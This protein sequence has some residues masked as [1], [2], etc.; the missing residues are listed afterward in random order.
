MSKKSGERSP[1]KLFAKVLVIAVII[2]LVLCGLGFN[3]LRHMNTNEGEA[4][5]EAETT[6]QNPITF[7]ADLM[8][9]EKDFN[10]AFLGVDKDGTRTDV[11]FVAHMDAK[12]DKISLISVPRDTKVDVCKEVKSI[13][14]NSGYYVPD[15]CKINEVHAYAKENGVKCAIIQLEDLL[16]IDID[17]YGKIDLNG[18]VELVDEVGGIDIDVPSNMY[19][20]DPYQDLYINLQAGP[21]H[22]D[23]EH[24]EML[25][26]F[27]SYPQG[28]VQRVAV[29]QDF[30]KEVARKLLDPATVKSNITGYI[31]I[32][33]KY[34]DTNF[35]LSALM[36]YGNN[37]S[38][39]NPDDIVM[40][41]LPGEGGYIGETSYYLVNETEAKDAINRI[42][43]STGN[44]TGASANFDSRDFRI[45]VCNGGYQNGYAAKWRDILAEDG[46][47]VVSITTLGGEKTSYTRIIVSES[48]M[49]LDLLSYFKKAE[50]ME[51]V[52]M[53]NEGTDIRIILGTDE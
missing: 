38:K 47:N 10:M 32:F 44:N 53:L 27:R 20:Q 24:A 45:E 29:Q 43:R 16:G 9:K 5:E 46:Y 8:S 4:A 13:I 48:G 1:A 33:V 2:G 3:M 37:F 34:V 26:R 21:Q 40:E 22:L 7:V 12:N 25:V 14:G 11:I 30:L 31:N 17:Y 6:F 52:S 15:Q 51:D 18:F 19:Y 42:F 36:K 35:P 28:D 49:G 39:V 50:V 41:T 23:G